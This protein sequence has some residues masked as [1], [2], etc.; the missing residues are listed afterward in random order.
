MHISVYS[1][2]NWPQ[3]EYPW[4]IFPPTLPFLSSSF[5]FHRIY[6]T[7]P[8]SICHFLKCCH[9]SF[10]HLVALF[11]VSPANMICLFHSVSA[12]ILFS[13]ILFYM[14]L[15]SVHRSIMPPPSPPSSLPRSFPHSELSNDFMKW[16]A[17]MREIAILTVWHEALS[18]RLW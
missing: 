14:L 9:S 6:S 4:G 18:Q 11:L 3:Y 12:C 10:S 2:S 5:V 1:D 13:S 8:S 16:A 15:P 7:L 17:E